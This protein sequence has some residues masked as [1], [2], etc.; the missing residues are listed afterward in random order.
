MGGWNFAPVGWAMCNGQAMAISQNAA[1]FN[2]IGTTYG[3]D[4]VSV[5]NLPDLRGRLPVHVGTG[6][7][8]GQSGG[9][10]TVTL[11]INQIPGHSHSFTAQT[12]AGTAAS[13]AGSLPAALSGSSVYIQGTA[14]TALNAGSIP[15]SGG[16][17]QPHDNLQ[18]YLCVTFIIALTGIYPSQL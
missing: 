17:G 2:L 14:S 10:E 16:N 18:P 12:A 7:A 15:A 11:N 4:G 5:F 8:L 1:L 6:F 9:T 3:G 13:P